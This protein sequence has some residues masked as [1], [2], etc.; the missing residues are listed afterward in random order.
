MTGYMISE[1]TR[2]G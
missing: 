2:M 1:W